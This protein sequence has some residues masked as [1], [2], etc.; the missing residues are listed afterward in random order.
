M[1]GAMIAIMMLAIVLDRTVPQQD[2]SGRI[3]FYNAALIRGLNE[4][5][6]KSLY[7]EQPNRTVYLALAGAGHKVCPL[8]TDEEEAIKW[9]KQFL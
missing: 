9:L 7:C 1:P 5:V 4:H 3:E 8:F 6:K 2:H